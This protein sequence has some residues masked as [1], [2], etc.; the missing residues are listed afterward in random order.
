MLRIV[1]EREADR[2]AL[3]LEDGLLGPGVVELEQ[4]WRP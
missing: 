3:K 4:A 2:I 1:V